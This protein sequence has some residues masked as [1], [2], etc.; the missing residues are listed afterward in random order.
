MTAAAPAAGAAQDQDERNEGR[1]W[2]SAA[3]AWWVMAV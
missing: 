2:P 3:R 1:S